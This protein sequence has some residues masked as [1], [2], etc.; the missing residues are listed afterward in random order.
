MSVDRFDIKN[1]KKIVSVVLD[2][3]TDHLI[4]YGGLYNETRPCG[5]LNIWMPS[6][7]YRDSHYNDETII[8]IIGIPI[9]RKYGLYNER[10]P[11]DLSQYKDRLSKYRDSHVKD[12][13]VARPSCLQHGYPILVRRHFYIEIAPC[14]LPRD[15]PRLQRIHLSVL[16]HGPKM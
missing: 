6:Y 7:Q 12:K 8:S 5:R 9:P 2:Y 3:C 13:M 14:F 11:W 1:L 15:I 16:Y 4:I 10:T